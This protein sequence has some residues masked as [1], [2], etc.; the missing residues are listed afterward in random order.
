VRANTRRDNGK[1][2]SKIDERHQ[3]IDSSSLAN[4]KQD[5]YLKRILMEAYLNGTIE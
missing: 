5:K 4:L 3:P 1:T 2:F